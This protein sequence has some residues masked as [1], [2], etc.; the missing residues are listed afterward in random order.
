MLGKLFKYE[1]KALS[2]T[3]LPLGIGVLLVA[4]FGSLM[5]KLNML[6]SHWIKHNSTVVSLVRSVTGT[7]FVFSIIAIISASVVAVFII[8]QRYYRSLFTDEGYLTFTLPVKIRDILFS[9]V[10]AGVLWSLFVMVCT[11]LG[12]FLILL[13]GTTRTLMNTD[14]LH[15][16]REAWRVFLQ[17]QIPDM[18]LPVFLLQMLVLMLASMLQQFLLIY[19]A[20]TLG[21]Q[22]AK[23]HKVLGAVAMYFVVYAICQSINAVLIIVGST[24]VGGMQFF[25]TFKPTPILLHWFLLG[26]TLL[27]LVY[28]A[29]FFVV[30]HRIIKNKLNLE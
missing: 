13:F 28:A 22:V 24:V 10:F 3:V 26:T 15:T 27:A 18:N 9:K 6:V 19:L 8:M 30:N 29:V 25:D 21:N 20:I 23:K 5:M 14:F 16:L 11:L 12:V 17:V 1:N 7:L 4:L 2:K